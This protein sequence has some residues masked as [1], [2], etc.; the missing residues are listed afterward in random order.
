[1]MRI[2]EKVYKDCNGQVVSLQTNIEKLVEKS[3]EVNEDMSSFR[4]EFEANK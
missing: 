1:M 2:R 4:V 3:K